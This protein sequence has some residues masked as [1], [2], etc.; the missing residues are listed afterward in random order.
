MKHAI[1]MTN[2]DIAKMITLKALDLDG[3]VLVP[4]FSHI[5]NSQSIIWASLSPKYYDINL[6]YKIN[7]VPKK[8]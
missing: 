7:S 5:S 8:I 4:A 3:N 6:N 1:C 2:T